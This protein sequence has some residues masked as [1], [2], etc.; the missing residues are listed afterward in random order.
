MIRP[1]FDGFSTGKKSTKKWKNGGGGVAKAKFGVTRLRA[2]PSR[3]AQE[4]LQ[5]NKI[6]TEGTYI[7]RINT[8]K[9]VPYLYITYK[10]ITY[11]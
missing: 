1:I 6:P 11:L 2:E 3:C 8:K 10:E 5:F 4:H 7:N 9:N